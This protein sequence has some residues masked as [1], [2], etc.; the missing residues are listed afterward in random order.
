[1]LLGPWDLGL[2]KLFAVKL[3]PILGDRQKGAFAQG[4]LLKF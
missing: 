4:G 1:M 2:D 3:G